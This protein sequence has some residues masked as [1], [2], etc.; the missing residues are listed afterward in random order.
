MLDVVMKFLAGELNTYLLTRTD[1]DLFNVERCRLVDDNGKSAV[2]LN[3]VGASVINVEEER[4]VKSQLPD[5]VYIDGRLVRVEPELRLN[6]YVVFAANFQNYDE[7]LK[8]I[9]HILT[10]FQA[11]HSFTQAEYPN[12]DSRIEK[13]MVELQSLTYEQLN[14]VWAFIGGKQLPSVIYKVRMVV[15]QDVEQGSIEPPITKISATSRSR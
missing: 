15:L 11:H 2:K 9:S 1:S 12:L 6:L 10:F 8:Y 4:T 5:Q 14:Q 7:A 13:L 3:Q